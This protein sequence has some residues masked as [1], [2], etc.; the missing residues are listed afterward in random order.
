MNQ[1]PIKWGGEVMG[2]FSAM[3][4]AMPS[5]LA[6]GVTILSVLGPDYAAKGALSGML[7]VVILGA[8][9]SL[10]GRTQRLISAPS[11]PAAAVLAA[12][13]LQLVDAGT[14]TSSIFLTLLL[15]SLLSAGI[16]IAM[17]LLRIGELIKFMPFPVVSGYLTGVGVVII[18][19]QLPKWLALPSGMSIWQ[20]ITMPSL[21]QAPSL[22]MG[23]MTAL[24]MV[25]APRI[26]QRIPAVIM[27]LMAGVITYWLLAWSSHPELQTLQHNAYVIGALNLGGSGIADE[28]AGTWQQL[29][30][31]QWPSLETVIWPAAT[32]AVLLSIDTL[33][34][35]VVLDTLTNT[36]HNSNRELLGQGLGN[37]F[38]A[39]S[40]GTA[41][42]GMMGATLINKASGGQTHW[43]SFF[44][45]MWSLLAMV[46]LMPFLAWIPVASLA[47]LLVVVGVRMIDWRA[48]HLLKTR[49]T[50]FDFVIII[51]V[52]V[53]ANTVS[54]IAASGFG[55]LLATMLFVNEQIHTSTIRRK[56]YGHQISSTRSRG[57]QERDVL[58]SHSQWTVVFELQGS[59]FFGTT[60]QLF[61]AIEP[62]LSSAK[63]VVLDFLRVQSMDM[64]ASHM[65]ERIRNTLAERD[66]RLVLTRVPERL[67][68]GR[69]LRSYVDHMG[70]LSDR[71]ARLFNDFDEALEWVEEETLR[72]A[73]HEHV[74]GEGLQLDAFELFNG[75]SEEQ[76]ELLKRS[77]DY[78]SFKANEKIFAA[79]TEG[80]EL[81]LISR[82]EVKVSLPMSHD[83]NIHLTI[84]SRG[85]FF[86]EMSFLDGRPHSADVHA[87]HD[88]D[89][90][91][92]DRRAFARLAA[93]DGVLSMNV[94]RSV[95]LAI[96][97]RLRH[98]ND[99]LREIRE[100]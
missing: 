30:L 28:V 57:Q 6:F 96:A 66:A 11:A 56:L 47:A 12:L 33:K 40:G 92:I 17:G 60:D 97:D 31:S 69:D 1:Q 61:R 100:A 39:L 48:T 83:D 79:Q 13:A 24:V 98:A 41:G 18:T 65:I 72:L 76:L 88:T 34:T 91:A 63:F 58:Q 5:A 45:S 55:I 29:M 82:G 19:S 23:A 2:G 32:L 27:G 14:P 84:F 26:S 51:A 90:I 68:S 62:E 7:G 38:V 50:S 81:M 43:S 64:T 89:L 87:V 42:S 80:H 71:T 15:V 25:I 54:L 53:V 10:I 22:W 52:A 86:G 49:D 8:F 36:R 21:W 44:Q 94:M 35:C 20:G 85:Q 3:L 59:L 95:A 70:L 93:S 4:V 74:S 99:Q 46:V 37:L 67:P 16:Q 75:L 77:V 78:R 73:G 9:A